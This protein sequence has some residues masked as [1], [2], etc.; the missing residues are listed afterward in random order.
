MKSSHV[1][2]KR[3][4]FQTWRRKLNRQHTHALNAGFEKMSLLNLQVYPYQYALSTPLLW[5][6]S[7]QMGQDA[8]FSRDSLRDPTAR[9]LFVEYLT[10]W[11]WNLNSS[12]RLVCRLLGSRDEKNSKFLTREMKWAPN[13]RVH[14]LVGL[15]L[16]SLTFSHCEV[17]NVWGHFRD[18][19]GMQTFLYVLQKEDGH[20]HKVE[21]SLSPTV[22]T[23]PSTQILL[24]L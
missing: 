14:R 11:I 8:S 17:N 9:S 24:F 10:V 18:F 6:L 3:K 13:V 22:E 20:V 7:H 21:R 2:K 16:K 19:K 15:N 12:T 23:G 5:F 1:W 4:M